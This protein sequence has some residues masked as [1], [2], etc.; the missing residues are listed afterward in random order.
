ML[1]HKAVSFKNRHLGDAKQPENV[2][3][4][5]QLISFELPW[6]YLALLLFNIFSG[7]NSSVFEDWFWKTWSKQ[8]NE[9]LSRAES[10]EYS[11]NCFTWALT[12]CA[13]SIKNMIFPSLP[14]SLPSFLLPSSPPPSLFSSFSSLFYSFFLGSW[15]ASVKRLSKMFSAWKI[16]KINK[17]SSKWQ[18]EY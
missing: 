15:N 7:D 14:T 13:Y 10:E 4:I 3:N 5:S 12:W 1:P 6:E 11:N 18:P 17:Y 8:K 9:K 16:Y 2:P